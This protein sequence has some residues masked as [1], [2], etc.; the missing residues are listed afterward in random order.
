MAQPR[1]IRHRAKRRL[2]GFMERVGFVKA[3]WKV[4][5]SITAV[6]SF[7]HTSALALNISSRSESLF[8]SAAAHIRLRVLK[9]GHR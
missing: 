9:S 6:K 5:T 1:E 4:V 2:N 8:Y 3:D 7:G